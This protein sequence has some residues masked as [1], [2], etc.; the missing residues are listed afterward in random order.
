MKKI[1]LIIVVASLSLLSEGALN[2]RQDVTVS[3][4]S[5]SLR[6]IVPT[7]T[8]QE[9]KKNTLVETNSV[10][11]KGSNENRPYYRRPAGAFYAPYVAVNGRGFNY[12]GDFSYI[13]VKPYSSYTYR[14]EDVN[15][16]YF[17]W[18]SDELDENHVDES[19]EHTVRYDIMEQVPPKLC[20]TH[21]RD[22]SEIVYYFQYLGEPAGRPG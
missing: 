20:F 17:Y 2:V 7:A 16:Y 10:P 5:M 19:L 21:E 13:L 11:L 9:M 14:A 12:Y 22:E 18:Q 6:T 15:N 4:S 8:T 1:L 3:R